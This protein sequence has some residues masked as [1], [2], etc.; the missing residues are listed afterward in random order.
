M[1]F[2]KSETMAK[3]PHTEIEFRPNGTPS[4]I[5]G[6]NLA[7]SLMPMTAF[8]AAFRQRNHREMAFLFLEYYKNFFKLTDPRNELRIE[9]IQLDDIGTTHL[10]LQQVLDDRPVWGK[11]ILL[12]LNKTDAIYL[13]QG[14][15]VPSSNLEKVQT[16]I[17]ITA[18]QAVA[19]ALE[20]AFDSSLPW[21]VEES[22]LVIFPI[23]RQ[24]PR[25]AYKITLT[26]GL[27]HRDR[28]FVD[29][30]DGRILHK[31]SLIRQ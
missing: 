14:D 3:P 24:L 26:S 31:M 19:K 28:Y 22:A 4:R 2:P 29:A 30:E 18:E 10:Q 17:E 27:V 23:E 15:Y 11:T 20:N 21:T 7:A 9:K 13:V 25:L 8:Q 6:D 5:K 16:L 1:N 12:H